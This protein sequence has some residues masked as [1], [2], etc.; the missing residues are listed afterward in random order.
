MSTPDYPTGLPGVAQ[1]RIKP[2]AQVLAGD[3]P[4]GPR[5]TR[6]RSVVPGAVGQAGWTFIEEDYATFVAWWRTT[7]L[8]GHKWFWIELPSAG[9]ITWHVVRFNGPYQARLNGHRSYVVSAEL[10]VRERQFDRN[11]RIDPS[12]V[13]V[14]DFENGFDAYELVQG[15]LAPFRIVEGMTG[16][17]MHADNY[18]APTQAIIE[19]VLDGP[20]NCAFFSFR[21]RVTS[22]GSDDALSLEL[23]EG[24]TTHF[25]FIPTREGFYNPAR[26]SMGGFP[27]LVALSV[28]QVTLDKIYRVEVTLEVGTN[29][30]RVDFIDE[31]NGATLKT[32]YF[33]KSPFQ[34]DR[35]RFVLDP[36][37]GT[38][39]TEYDDIFARN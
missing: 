6:R 20:V 36:S 38:C 33:T 13:F 10:E 11:D 28:V 3:N 24:T 14:E 30:T 9:G 39:Q 27:S 32:T 12:V 4:G 7:L 8:R 2:T 1:W 22:F 18:T 35:I 21:F 5:D 19:R 23:R 29:A 34:F 31:T 26:Q 25:A 37:V 17:A 15:S 16:H